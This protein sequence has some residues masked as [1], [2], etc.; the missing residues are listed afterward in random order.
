MTSAHGSLPTT[1]EISPA[2]AEEL[3][4]RMRGAGRRADRAEIAALRDAA[5]PCIIACNAWVARLNG[6]VARGLLIE[7]ASVNRSYPDLCR[8]AHALAM[9]GAS[10]EWEQACNLAGI[11]PN[12]RIDE[13]AYRSLVDAV[14]DASSLDEFAQR[15][16]VAVLGRRPLALRVRALQELVAAAPRNGAVRDLARR[17]EHEAVDHL[18]AACRA[19]SADGRTQELF[20]A[21]DA[22]EGLEWQSHFSAEFVGWLRSA[23]RDIEVART[24]D[25]FRALADRV[26]RAFDAKDLMLVGALEEEATRLESATG[27]EPGEDFR[28]ATAPAFRWA[29]EQRTSLRRRADHTDRCEA[30]RNALDQNYPYTELEPLRGRILQLEMGIPDDIEARF[31]TVHSAWRSEKRR[32]TATVIALSAIAL[33]AALGGIGFLAHRVSVREQA[34]LRAQGLVRLLDE[35]RYD[36][37]RKYVEE[38]RLDDPDAAQTPEFE[39]AVAR[40]ENERPAFDRRRTEIAAMLDEA[41]ALAASDQEGME[42]VMARLRQA[43]DDRSAMGQLTP[44]E[45]SR[46]EALLRDFEGRLADLRV[47]RERRW[48]ELQE[49]LRRKVAA[50]GDLDAR[51]A[52]DRY[53][54]K[55]LA[56]YRERL[57]E[58]AR[59]LDKLAAELPASHP[60]LSAVQVL[61]ER[62]R[63]SANGTDELIVALE[64]ASSAIASA[65]AA[66]TEAELIDAVRALERHATVLKARNGAGAAGEVADSMLAAESAQAVLQWREGVAVVLRSASVGD[67]LGL[68]ATASKCRRVLGALESHLSTHPT[69]P[70]RDLAQRWAAQCRLVTNAKNVGESDPVG[71]AAVRALEESGIM[72]LSQV[73]LKGGQWAFVRDDIQGGV[74]QLRGLVR[75]ASELTCAPGALG[76]P[77]RWKDMPANGIRA[78]AP[79]VTSF[80]SAKSKLLAPEVSLLESQVAYLRML[81]EVNDTNGTERVAQAGVLSIM[82]LAFT[83]HLFDCQD[84]GQPICRIAERRP[85]DFA[86]ARDWP[87]LSISISDAERSELESARNQVRPVLSGDAGS[88]EGIARSLERQWDAEV[89]E[90][91]GAR[92]V[93]TLLP[94]AAGET[95]RRASAPITGE[96]F[97]LLRYDRGL[98]R[99]VLEPAIFQGGVIRS[100]AGG[101]PSYAPIFERTTR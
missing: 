21:L 50:L 64:A 60:E 79:W 44:A 28:L 23:C 63:S 85:Q 80:A 70:Y 66:D 46:A 93:A 52:R 29:E 91:A 6:W 74:G 15:F 100:G 82:L 73:E 97:L 31:G 33:A 10:L 89:R 1:P 41:G 57:A 75:G 18:E 40:L 86:G 65:E 43:M 27:M 48:K 78:P 19:A 35:R 49:D 11:P 62:I 3:V 84:R 37:A 98:Q 24:A 8:V 20:D 71:L 32:R 47:S 16:Q 101:A 42:Q 14:G 38:V 67:R 96:G 69:S 92:M 58:L 9:P 99:G 81:E 34:L 5:E 54:P 90:A 2:Q 7:A 22:I 56:E 30:M 25:E 45:R 55:L 83:E 4:A 59:E 94:L 88:Y 77:K 13:P 61:R 12:T 72:R 76:D 36:V 17:Y 87:R 95:E 68:P 51:T 26:A 39:A 53:D